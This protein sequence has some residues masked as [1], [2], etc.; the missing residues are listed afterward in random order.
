MVCPSIVNEFL[1]ILRMELLLLVVGL[2]ADKIL[3]KQ[4]FFHIPS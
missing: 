1:I 3:V 4:P 2:V